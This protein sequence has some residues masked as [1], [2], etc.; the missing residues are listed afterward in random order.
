[1]KKDNSSRT[2]LREK[3]YRTPNNDEE[4]VKDKIYEGEKVE[5]V[6]QKKKF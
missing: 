4:S 3:F 1:M 6:N 5:I 2:D